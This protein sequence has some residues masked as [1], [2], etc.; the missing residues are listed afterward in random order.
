MP[1]ETK[2]EPIRYIDSAKWLFSNVR[3]STK[4][5]A[6][7]KTVDGKFVYWDKEGEGVYGFFESRKE[8]TKAHT[9][10][11]E[12]HNTSNLTTA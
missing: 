4:G 3:A 8:A 12:S 7:C 2:Q 11:I 5:D 6:V 9:A 10:Y 1:E